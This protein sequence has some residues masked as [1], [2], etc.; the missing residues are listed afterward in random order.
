LGKEAYHAYLEWWEE[1]NF[2]NKPWSQ[3]G[4]Y[5]AME[6]RGAVRHKMTKGITLLGVRKA[7]VPAN[8][9]ANGSSNHPVSTGG[10]IFER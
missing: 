7:D 8:T 6:E 4:F 1:N 9:P 2:P 5:S 3:P 10:N